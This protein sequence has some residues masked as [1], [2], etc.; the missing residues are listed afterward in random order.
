[1]L[2]LLNQKHLQKLHS[3]DICIVSIS[4]LIDWYSCESMRFPALP[5]ACHCTS[6][7]EFYS[8]NHN[9]QPTSFSDIVIFFLCSRLHEANWYL[10]L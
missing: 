5:F 1:M 10:V 4:L 7:E 8:A 6:E 3:K 2:S 9:I